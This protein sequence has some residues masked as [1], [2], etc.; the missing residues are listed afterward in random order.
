MTGVWCH[1]PA[2][3]TLY[4]RDS[5][6]KE[7]RMFWN[8]IWRNEQN[9]TSHGKWINDTERKFK[10][11]EEQKLSN[12]DFKEAKQSLSKSLKIKSEEIDKVTWNE[13]GSKF[14]KTKKQHF[15]K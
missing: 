6:H 5:P 11:I 3:L 4:H 14:Y 8:K 13:K 15:P 2:H 7:V 1:G 9:Y 12:I 10:M